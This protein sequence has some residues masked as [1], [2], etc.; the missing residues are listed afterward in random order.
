MTEREYYQEVFSEILN[1]EYNEPLKDGGGGRT[2]KTPA[3]MANKAIDYFV[4]CRE[5]GDRPNYPGLRIYMKLWSREA[6]SKYANDVRQYKEEFRMVTD[7]IRLI[8]EDKIVQALY[9]KNTYNGARFDLQANWNWVPSEKQI[10]ESH[11][12][13]VTLGKKKEEPSS[14]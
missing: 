12:I 4:R 3:E 6:F 2:Y 11:T 13:N 9:E 14:E 10:I 1:K 8:I 5:N 7:I